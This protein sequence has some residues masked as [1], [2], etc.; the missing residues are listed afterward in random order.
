[1]PVRNAKNISVGDIVQSPRF[2]YGEATNR[3]NPR[4]GCAWVGASERCRVHHIEEVTIEVHGHRIST[5]IPGDLHKYDRSDVSRREA[6]FV[7]VSTN[8]QGGGYG[9]HGPGDYYPDGLYV[10]A[11]RLAA[12]GSYDPE[13]ELIA[14]YMSGCFRQMI[15]E[16]ELTGRMETRQVP[17]QFVDVIDHD[18]GR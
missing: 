16:V 10:K 8:M 7:V 12:D 4:A 3:D 2:V 13:G 15:L 14:F 17:V 18:L 6:K 11:R 5:R 9:G 1:M